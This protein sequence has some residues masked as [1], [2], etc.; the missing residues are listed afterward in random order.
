MD[1]RKW[2][3]DVGLVIPPRGY[4]LRPADGRLFVVTVLSKSV[5][6]HFA[7]LEQGIKKW[8]VDVEVKSYSK[9]FFGTTKPIHTVKKSIFSFEEFTAFIND[10]LPERCLRNWAADHHI[11][12]EAWSQHHYPPAAQAQPG[13]QAHPATPASLAWTEDHI[14]D[15]GEGDDE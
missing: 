2:D 9:H 15:M 14:S 1:A 8:Y 10:S 5:V 13:T 4:L 11:D 6:W 12:M 3:R 7:H